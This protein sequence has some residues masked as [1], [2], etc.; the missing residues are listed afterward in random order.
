MITILRLVHVVGGVFWV[1]TMLFFAIFLEPSMREAGPAAAKISEGLMKRGYMVAMPI[2]ALL[3]IVSGI[4]MMWIVSGHFTPQWMGSPMGRALSAGMTLS[5][6]TFGIGVGVVRP[7][8]NKTVA[9]GQAVAQLPEGAE[10]TAQMTALQALR[11][12]G[13][14]WLRV[15]ASLLAVVASLMA[16]ARYL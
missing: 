13:T 7:T 8:M 4:W 5:I 10:K 12:R 9:M 1:G 11:R 14:M 2:I 15:V 3:V 6:I 16:V